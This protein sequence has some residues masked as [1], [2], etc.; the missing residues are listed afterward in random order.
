MNDGAL[1]SPH[2]RAFFAGA[3]V[4]TVLTLGAWLSSCSSLPS[5]LC[6]SCEQ[7]CPGE[8]ECNRG[9]CVR[10]EHAAECD[11]PSA[12]TGTEGGTP[13]SGGTGGDAEVGDGTS[14]AGGGGEDAGENSPV[15]SMGLGN[16]GAA[17]CSLEHPAC[18]PEL[19]TP[20]RLPAVCSGSEIDI[21]LEA[22]C[23]CDDAGAFHSVTWQAD[24][25]PPGLTLESSG[26]LYGSL[27]DGTHEFEVTA[28]VDDRLVSNDFEVTV[29]DRCLVLFA[30]SESEGEPRRLAAARIDSGERVPL[31][32]A[33]S[34][35]SS[36][37]AFDTSPNGRFL[38]EVWDAAGHR[39]LRLLEL[40]ATE[41]EPLAFE[42]SGDYLGHAFSRDSGWLGLV[43][44]SA[45][46]APQ[47]QFQIVDLRNQ[48]TRVVDVQSVDY[49]DG[50]AW[51]DAGG[52]LYRA[53]WSQDSLYFVAR[54]R[55]VSPSGFGS[56]E[57]YAGTLV[58]N[59]E[60]FH[61]F[62]VSDAGFMMLYQSG[63]PYFDRAEHTVVYHPPVQALSPDLHWVAQNDSKGVWVTPMAKPSNLVTDRVGCDLVRAWSGKA[64]RLVCTLNHKLVV[65][66]IAGEGTLEREAVLTDILDSEIRRIALSESGRWLAVT[67]SDAG[68]IVMSAQ[69]FET[70]AFDEPTLEAPSG[71]N[72]WDYFFTPDE[73]RLVVQRGRK[74]LVAALA[75]ESRLTASD[76]DELDVTLPEVPE[77][78][79]GWYPDP[80]RWCGAP[81]YRGNV[82]LSPVGRHIA[83]EDIDGVL[84]VT[85]L[86][87]Q[88]TV[89]IGPVVD[90][91][92]SDSMLLP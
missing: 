57:E 5:A 47:K 82:A 51:S 88:K 36:L 24:A 92:S 75:D 32:L 69:E 81:R 79:I 46:V 76:F 8:L 16:A 37:A 62:F 55:A 84:H 22:G 12:V 66:D 43:T 29:L 19:R 60:E 26:R 27:R 70:R 73:S 52:L 49:H 65:Y 25:L 40:S 11:D 68:F 13:N 85:S 63:L 3:V 15:S 78:E 4:A 10:P 34:A 31:P 72:E 48:P 21:E 23:R 53:K 28:T 64:S 38:A 58:A 86:D 42:Y 87:T 61:R 41:A 80:N 6:T 39:E 71:K 30:T 1:E 7:S 54:E 18:D 56:E 2:Q 9:R 91:P 89:T 50:F 33:P 14:A 35:E 74:L 77:C 20:L 67:P 45:D 90:L 44:S 59:T 83:F 17:D